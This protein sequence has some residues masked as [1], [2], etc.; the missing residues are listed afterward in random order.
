MDDL[1]P[2]PFCGG[3]A[4]LCSSQICPSVDVVVECVECHAGTKFFNDGEADELRREAIEAWNRRVEQN[5]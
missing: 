2:C 4:R 3:E 5:G 1:L